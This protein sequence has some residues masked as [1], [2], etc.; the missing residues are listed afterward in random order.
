[1]LAPPSKLASALT[2]N[3]T[4]GQALFAA[5]FAVGYSGAFF[6]LIVYYVRGRDRGD[7]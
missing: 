4:T 3:T 1:M 5:A 6:H 7:W 2:S